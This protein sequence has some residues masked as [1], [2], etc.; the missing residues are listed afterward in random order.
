YETWS[1]KT[2]PEMQP[3]M[4]AAY[5]E[6][7]Q[8]IGALLAP[9]GER[10]HAYRAAHPD[11]EMYAD[12]GAHASPAGSAFAASVIWETIRDAAENPHNQE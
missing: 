7:A 6:I 12:D 3:V 2:E 9:V 8:E 1:Q 10:W 4:N 5:R 11:V